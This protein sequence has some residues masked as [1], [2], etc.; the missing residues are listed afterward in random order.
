V[1]TPNGVN[2]TASNTISIKLNDITGVADWYL[3]VTGTDET[4]TNPTLTGVNIITSLVASPGTVVTFTMAAGAG[5]AFLFKSIVTGPGGPVETSFAIYVLTVHGFRVGATGE[6]REGNTNFGWASTLNP[7]IRTGAGVIRFDDS[8]TSPS[9][10]SA[11][12]Q[13]IIDYLKGITQTGGDLIIFTPAAPHMGNVFGDWAELCSYIGTLPDGSNPKIRFTANFTIPSVGMP[14]TGWPQ[15][16]G[17]WESNS[18]NTGA[19]V[20]DIPDGVKIDML[21]GINNGLGVNIHPSSEYGVFNWSEFAPGMDPW[22]LAVGQGAHLANQGTKAAIISPGIPFTQTYVVIAFNQATNAIPPPNTAPWV[23]LSNTDVAILSQ[24]VCG[25]FGGGQDGWIVGTGSSLIYINGADSPDPFITPGPF[26]AHYPA[27]WV[28]P[29]PSKVQGSAARNINYDDTLA[30]PATGATNTQEIIDFLKSGVGA[31]RPPITTTIYGEYSSADVP[32][33]LDAPFPITTAGTI[34][35]LRIFRR[36]PGSGIIGTRVNVKLNG[37]SLFVAAPPPPEVFPI[38]GAY[39]SSSAL[40]STP[41]VP[42]DR[43]EFYLESVESFSAGPTPQE[44]GPEGLTVYLDLG[45]L[46]EYKDTKCLALLSH[47]L[48]KLSLAHV[49]SSLGV[50]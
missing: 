50:M 6:E 25:P 47:R 44:D 19:I 30:L 45:P 9:T 40:T 1:S 32:G 14:P 20:V 41:V 24:V 3:Q 28:G 31:G 15:G 13:Q 7:L 12:T 38:D 5:R 46:T 16:K 34:T 42:G 37:V 29:A 39:A 18:L 21:M 11:T 43:V 26:V 35:G 4:S 33:L 22:I 2:V 8:L 27:G 10:G 23:K 48:L 36:R 49:T 17:T